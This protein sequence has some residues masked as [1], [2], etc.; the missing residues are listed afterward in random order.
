V[1][2]LA[3]S[4]ILQLSVFSAPPGSYADAH[5]ASMSSGEPLLV[6]VGANWCPACVTMKSSVVPELQRRGSFKGVNFAQ[7]DMDRQRAMAGELSNGGMIPK[8]ILFRKTDTGWRKWEVMG[9]QSPE[10]V[11][12]F[13]RNGLPEEK[14]ASATPVSK[15]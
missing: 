9:A 12:Q 11:E 6:L 13:I 1:N 7:V 3:A 14:T 15:R 8:L 4:L 10:S 5:K 2:S